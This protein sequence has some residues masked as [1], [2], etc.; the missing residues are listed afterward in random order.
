VYNT[1]LAAQSFG[2]GVSIAA[3]PGSTGCT[4][5]YVAMRYGL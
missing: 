1:L 2:L 3:V 5:K 4:I